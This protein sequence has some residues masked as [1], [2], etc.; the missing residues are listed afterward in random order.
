MN[1]AA[2][3]MTRREKIL[4]LL[5]ADEGEAG[6]GAAALR[7]CAGMLTAAYDVA[8]ADYERL[9]LTEI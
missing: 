3:V 1:V 2:T 7:E 4:E 6:G 8:F 9:A 5:C